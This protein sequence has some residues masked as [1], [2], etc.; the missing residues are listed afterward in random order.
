M[1]DLN[2]HFPNFYAK[3]PIVL[4]STNWIF[5]LLFIRK[6]GEIQFDNQFLWMLMVKKSNHSSIIVASNKEEMLYFR[7]NIEILKDLDFPCF[8]SH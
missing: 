2:N 3:N 6:E 1:A 5:L 8:Y 7:N 4:F